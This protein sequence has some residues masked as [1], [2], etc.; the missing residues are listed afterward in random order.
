MPDRVICDTSPLC[1]LHRLR[2]FSLL[3]KTISRILVPEAV[4]AEFS[5]NDPEGVIGRARPAKCNITY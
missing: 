4:V 5:K 2:Q 3:Q 1:Y